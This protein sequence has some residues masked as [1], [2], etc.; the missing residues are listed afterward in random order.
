MLPRD[1][2]TL[3]L[4]EFHTVLLLAARMVNSTPLWEAPESPNTAQPITPHHLITQRDDACN[5]SDVR[6]TV[7]TEKDLAAYGANRWRRVQALAEEFWRGW[8]HYIF[9]IGDSRQKWTDPKRNAQVGDV[10][11]IKDKNLPRLEWS[12]GTI[13]ETI[14]AQDGL[15]RRVI[16]QPHKRSDKSTTERPRERAIHDLVLLKEMH[17]DSPNPTLD[18]K[19]L[20][21]ED[22]RHV[23][24]T[25]RKWQ[26]PPIEEMSTTDLDWEQEEQL[27]SDIA[28]L[29]KNSEA[30]L[31]NIAWYRQNVKQ[32][33]DGSNHAG[34]S[35]LRPILKHN[36]QSFAGPNLSGVQLPDEEAKLHNLTGVNTVINRII[37]EEEDVEPPNQIKSKRRIWWPCTRKLV[38]YFPFRWPKE[39]STTVLPEKVIILPRPT[40]ASPIQERKSSDP[41]TIPMS[42]GNRKENYKR[43]RAQLF[44][45]K[46]QRTGKREDRKHYLRHAK[47]EI[48]KIWKAICPCLNSKHKSQRV[49][50][51]TSSELR[52]VTGRYVNRYFAEQV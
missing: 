44:G 32:S 11:L 50:R 6:F 8:K 17:T 39:T 36:L 47:Q 37:K 35:S 3:T 48:I 29:Q 43:I 12:T 41:K 27:H 14:T 34:T 22:E 15:V 19:G 51:A 31:Q 28:E 25:A 9:S 21:E 10:V 26:D 24:R 46:D 42:F 30:M 1:Q 5:E 38:A 2:R 49:P 13:T 23:L 33:N 18:T 4:Y 52:S 16:V 20:S 40:S 7:Y 45:E